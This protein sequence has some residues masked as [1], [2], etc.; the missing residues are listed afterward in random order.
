ML[1]LHGVTLTPQDAENLATTLLEEGLSPVSV[2]TADLIRRAV[3]LGFDSV[4]LTPAQS[5]AIIAVLN[6]PLGRTLVAL[7]D[8]LTRDLER[9]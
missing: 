9:S 7:R 4:T 5:A 2:A 8:K 6:E 3:R 1:R